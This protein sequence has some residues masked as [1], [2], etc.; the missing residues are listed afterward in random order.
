MCLWSQD[1]VDLRS[2]GRGGATKETLQD[3][4]R[5]AVAKKPAG[6]REFHAFA[7]SRVGG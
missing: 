7:M 6:C 5:E 4:L 1:E 3:A 2:L